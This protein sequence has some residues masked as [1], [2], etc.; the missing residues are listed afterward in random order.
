[1][2]NADSSLNE[3]MS[4]LKGAHGIGDGRAMDRV[5]DYFYPP[6]KNKVQGWKLSTSTATIAALP[7][8]QITPILSQ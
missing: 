8:F 1:M 4:C 3:T 7:D 5:P 6:M 2:D